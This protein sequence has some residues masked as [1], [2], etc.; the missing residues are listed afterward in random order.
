MSAHQSGE[1]SIALDRNLADFL[2][3]IVVEREGDVH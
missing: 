1:R 2:D 3:E